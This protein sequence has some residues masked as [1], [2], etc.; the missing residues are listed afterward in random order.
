MSGLARAS[1]CRR[2]ATGLLAAAAVVAGAAAPAW[3]HAVLVRSSPPHRAVVAQAPARVQLWFNEAIE[4]AYARLTVLDGAGARV[5]T[6]DV[7]VGADDP[8]RLSVALKPLAPG[9]YVARYRV[10]S[11]DGHVIEGELT[12]TI[13]SRPARP[14]EKRP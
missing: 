3:G 2:R 11:V 6:D 10:L 14:Q 8:R 5:D 7:A 9:R 1:G 4:P 13:G 12:F